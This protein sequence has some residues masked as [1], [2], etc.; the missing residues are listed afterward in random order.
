[1]PSSAQQLANINA[2]FAERI[3]SLC[4]SSTEDISDMPPRFDEVTA[5]LRHARALT[6]SGRVLSGKEEGAREI[7]AE[8][9]RHL[10]AI[11]DAIGR[12]EPLLTAR[13]A[14]L[15]RQLEHIRHAS[16]WASSVREVR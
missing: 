3:P 4:C 6:G 11:R 15:H 7:L 13:R 5:L 8:Y 14:E 2:R 10:I 1:M 12:M 9:R 16:C